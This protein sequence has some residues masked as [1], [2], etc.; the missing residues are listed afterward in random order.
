MLALGDGIFGWHNFLN[1][2][3]VNGDGL[4][5]PIDAL[6]VINELNAPMNSYP[7]TSILPLGASGEQLA[8]GLDVSCDGFVSPIDALLVINALNSKSFSH[9]WNFSSSGG[10]IQPTREASTGRCQPRLVESSSLLAELNYPFKVPSNDTLLSIKIRDQFFDQSKVGF[11][12]DALEVALVDEEGKSLVSPFT[13][14][15]E[16]LFN[17][18]E[19][20][21]F[22]AS[23]RVEFKQDTIVVDLTDIPVGT[24]GSVIVRLINN[25]LDTKSAVTIESIQIDAAGRSSNGQSAN[26]EDAIQH[27][28][29]DSK[30]TAVSI[31]SLLGTRI[32]EPLRTDSLPFDSSASLSTSPSRYPDR[33]IEVGEI[34]GG[35]LTTREE[36]DFY[37]FYADAGSI[38]HVDAQIGSLNSFR[39]KILSASSAPV[40]TNISFA[41]ANTIELPES[42]IYTFQI[43][44]FLPSS[45]HY[46]FQLWNVEPR[47]ANIDLD[48]LIVGSLDVPGAAQNY[49]FNGQVGQRIAF[50][51]LEGEGFIVGTVYEL[52]SPS[53]KKSFSGVQL[54]PE[55]V[56]DET[57]IYLLRVTRML[58][59]AFARSLGN[60]GN[61]AFRIRDSSTASSPLP[62]SNV[63]LAVTN[64]LWSSN[65]LDDTREIELSWTV[66]NLGSARSNLDSWSS[67]V[68]LVDTVE[69]ATELIPGY[70]EVVAD[71]RADRQ[72]DPGESYTATKSVTIPARI[73]GEF[74]IGVIADVHNSVFELD[75]E[76]N[77]AISNQLI[78][79]FPPKV[80]S[81]ETSITVST[82]RNVFE[83]GQ[84]ALLHGIAIPSRVDTNTIVVLDLS[85]S[86]GLRVDENGN[87]IGELEGIDTNG[88]GVL[89]ELDNAN[90]DTRTGDILD[91]EINSLLEIIAATP[92]NANRNIAVVAFGSRS[93]NFGYPL[94]P[95]V[96]LASDAF[97]QSFVAVSNESYDDMSKAIRSLS[98]INQTFARR[99]EVGLFHPFKIGSGNDLGLVMEEVE[100]LLSQA[101][102][103]ERTQIIFFADGEPTT[104]GDVTDETLER[105]AS[106]GV[107]FFGYQITGNSVSE[108]MQRMAR[109]IAQEPHSSGQTKLVSNPSNLLSAATQP[110]EIVSVTVNGKPVQALDPSG[111]F[112]AEVTIQEGDNDF[113]VESIDSNGT[114]A[115]IRIQLRGKPRDSNSIELSTLVDV[116]GSLTGVYGRT[117]FNA[118]KDQ[119]LVELATRN[120]GS[121]DSDIPVLVGIRNLSDP[122]IIVDNADGVFPDGMPYYD[123][124]AYVNNRRLAPGEVSGSPTISFRNAS[125]VQF[126]YELVFF[127]KLNAAP[128]ITSVP[129][130]FAEK[131]KPFVYKLTASD[132]DSD[133]LSYALIVSPN[134]MTIDPNDGLVTW[135]PTVDQ[136]GIHEVL[137]RVSDPRGGIAEQKFSLSVIVPP[138]NR[139]P[140]ITSFPVVTAEIGLLY[141][142][143]VSAR[144]SD[145]DVLSYAVLR[146]P[147]GMVIDANSG[148][149]R[150][151]PSENDLGNHDLEIKLD[152]GRGGK[153]IQRFVICVHVNAG[154]DPV[155]TPPVI[156]VADGLIASVDQ[157]FRTPVFVQ[158]VDA[159]PL[160]LSIKSAPPG[161][162]IDRIEV[163]DSLQQVA[164]VEHYITWTPS[165]DK[166]GIHA[167]VLEAVDGDGNRSIRE[168][169]LTVAPTAAN[170][171]PKI[172]S[173]YRES[174][175][176]GASFSYFAIAKDPDFDKLTWSLTDPPIGMTISD[177]GFVQWIP[178]LEQTGVHDI[179]LR[180]DDKRGGSDEQRLHLLVGLTLTNDPPRVVSSPKLI[181]SVEH[182]Y[183]YDLVAKDLDG[184][185]LQ[186]SLTSAPNGMSVH[187][188]NGTIR[189][190]P[191]EQ[192]YGIHKVVVTVSDIVGTTYDQSFSVEVICGN[193]P[194]IIE[195]S[196][197][198]QALSDRLYTYHVHASDVDDQLL[199]F[200]VLNGPDGLQI[201]TESGLIRWTPTIQQ[202]GPVGLTVQVSDNHGGVAIQTYELLVQ[203]SASPTNPN[204]PNSA[205]LGN[206]APVITSTPTF[207]AAVG[208]AYGYTVIAF[209][210]D[211][212][213]ISF[214][215]TSSPI[216]LTIDPN[217]GTLN[218]RPTTADEG[219][220]N[221]NVVATDERGAKSTQGYALAVRSNSLP[222]ITSLPNL[223]AVADG[224]YRYIVRATDID[225]DRLTY[226]LGHAI[227]GLRLDPSTGILTWLPAVSDLGIHLIDVV[228]SDGKGAMVAQQFNLEVVADKLAPQVKLS[229]SSTI[230]DIGG[231]VFLQVLATDNASVVERTLTVDGVA[232]PLD[233]LGRGHFTGTKQ[234]LVEVVATA[235]DAAGNV[236][237]DVL[238]IRILDPKDERGPTVSISS[239]AYDAEVSYLTDIVGTIRVPDGQQLDFYRI[240][241]APTDKVDL[242]NIGADSPHWKILSEGNTQV[243]NAKLATFDPTVLR[244]G[245]Y[246]VRVV[247]FNTNGQGWAEPLQLHAVGAAKIGQFN[248]EFIDLS[249]PLS[250]IPIQIV[251]KYDTLDADLEGDFGFGWSLQGAN[252]Q[253]LAAGLGTP[254][255]L[256]SSG[257]TFIPGKTK[258]Y[259]T[260]PNGERVGFSYSEKLISGGPLSAVYQPVFTADPGVYGALTAP[261]TI[262]RGMFG[263]LGYSPSE[264]TLATKQGLAYKYTKAGEL[265][266][267]TD[268]NGNVVTFSSGGIS[269]SNG[270][271]IDFKRDYRGRIGKVILPDGGE[272]KYAYDAVGDL[273]SFTNQVGQTHK[274]D[275][276][277][278]TSHFFAASFDSL[279][280]RSLKAVYS[281]D[282][283]FL[284]VE[285][286][287]GQVVNSQNFDV[288]AHLGVL[289]D[290]RGN[291]TTLEFDDRGNVLVETD[292][293]GFSK[294][295]FYE[296]PK[297]P[298]L[299]T[300][301]IEKDGHVTKREFDERGNLTKSIELGPLMMPFTNAMVTSYTYDSG[302]RVTSVT[303][304]RNN[305]TV[306]RYDG[307]GNL[308]QLT[309]ALGNSSYFTYS[310][311]G[312]VTD[313]T[314]FKG[315]DTRFDDYVGGQPRLITYGDGTRQR[316]EYN[317][318]G[319]TTYEAYLEPDG[320]IAWQRTQEY[321]QLGRL[322]EEV[323]G[324][325]T[326]GSATTRKL[327]YD[328][329]VLDWEIIVHPDSLNQNGTL[330]ESPSTPVAN[331]KSSITDYV[332]DAN[333]RLI[334][335]IDAEGGVINFRYDVDGNRIALR[336]PVG[337][338][339]TWLFDK[340]S[341]P[342]EERDPLY[343]ADVRA[344]E[345][346]FSSL[347]DDEFLELV[348][349]IDPTSASDP[350]FDDPSG[351]SCDTDTPAPHVILSCYDAVGNVEAKVDRNGRR[352]EYDFDFMR[353]LTEER[354]Y[355]LTDTLIRT[356]AYSFDRVGNM[357]AALDA[358]S[359]LTFTYDAINQQL[360]AD[361]AGTPQGPGVLL[362]YSYDANGNLE[363]VFDN[364]GIT[365]ASIYS[366]RNL[367]QVRQWFD[368]SEVDIPEI[369]PLR[370]E[371]SYNA[372]GRQSKTDRYASL[373][374]SKLIGHMMRE[375]DQAGRSTLI[376]FRNTAEE[377]L[378]H[379]AFK[380]DA[381]GRMAASSRAG[382]DAIYTSDLTGQ[383]TSATRSNSH[384]EFFTYD[385]NGNRTLPG[386]VTDIGNRLQT[387]GNYVYGYDAEGNRV[388][389]AEIDTGTITHYEYDHRNRLVRITEQKVNRDVIDIASYTY[390]VLD[391]RIKVE[392]IEGVT[393]TVHDREQAWVDFNEIAEVTTRYL[394]DNQIDML[395]AIAEK[396]QSNLFVNTDQLGSVVSYVNPNGELLR[397]ISYD[398]FGSLA[399]DSELKGRF[400][401]TGRDSDSATDLY[402]YRARYYDV[403]IGR[404]VSEDPIRFGGFDSQLT[405]YAQ[406]APPIFSDP[407]GLVAALEVGVFESNFSSYSAGLIGG[408]ASSFFS[409]TV[410]FAAEVLEELNI[411][412]GAQETFERKFLMRALKRAVYKS[413]ERIAEAAAGIQFNQPA[414]KGFSQG[415]KIGFYTAVEIIVVQ[416]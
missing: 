202:I 416:I 415:S 211:R 300:R 205:A 229:S 271:R 128:I 234:Q 39:Y 272:L 354:W 72:L 391:R 149:I 35:V 215:L 312:D 113:I 291:E 262:T 52:V 228:V 269:H 171:S 382:T 77:V 388:T 69:S 283:Q 403:S 214:S 386:Y 221:I 313:F 90:G 342:T 188:W 364:S 117:S 79:Y 323:L 247:A 73:I 120:D 197:K 261:G 282:N 375:Y 31:P 353:D 129:I 60:I 385:A 286:A 299:E 400:G 277:Q 193:V 78:T 53:G 102:K 50:D 155:D 275:Y 13:Q 103:A 307:N 318:Y 24:K 11:I 181:A 12:R 331:R 263:F 131:G 32:G 177:S 254:N 206:R 348:A 279:G 49:H 136:T 204:D 366:E 44:Q 107:D 172:N 127:A 258:V 26:S 21:P 98:Y 287:L 298:D 334:H 7:G 413:L 81:P 119:V 217:T 19:G 29:E 55:S 246:A 407:F 184:D 18:T 84:T 373:D 80:G 398:A 253:I 58:S 380:Y 378:S 57:G 14:N 66:T 265:Q 389:R 293:L 65:Q 314:D 178:T 112:F 303:D 329:E 170:L 137:L 135:A 330:I 218:W 339:T 359:S 185:I 87:V 213:E 248:L 297:N 175:V 99:S 20:L 42:G 363:S 372:A 74:Q 379:Y 142:Y 209:D 159:S 104:E 266:S 122:S 96:D 274:Y 138:P 257:G 337:N 360:T 192:Q 325:E 189:W 397:T 105:I 315:N 306:F 268:L 383:L 245:A 85:G 34:V 216:G 335:Q 121:F 223:Q 365:V 59:P 358:D 259:L 357:L 2:E 381:L 409:V 165:F 41:D 278:N 399:D 350:L 182:G 83:A 302:N 327:F 346:V 345:A 368:S 15:R 394:Y 156:V 369:A 285:D 10:Y 9:G 173:S 290:G 61:Y 321:D 132:P 157:I 317:I 4:V 139:P 27:L 251:R 111:Q 340:N 91:A 220:Y 239:P 210:A 411:R 174:L 267:I 284:H 109:L 86:T 273:R 390:D 43:E 183:R 190:N 304:A 243:E 405:R 198:T 115:S 396:S 241:I 168:L 187:P 162:S 36:I 54:P 68:F 153:T 195:S 230:I 252:A 408:F 244:N 301:I 370:F 123:F 393:F 179:L 186:F 308:A 194:P 108:P 144:D 201:N 219:Q 238:Q 167:V 296:D 355:D 232:V 404:F 100:R 401:F 196:P 101:P 88:D 328:G 227:P 377:I 249:I 376:D 414:A 166:I 106:Y 280:N 89:D 63:D 6:R 33:L 295:Y 347:S 160:L 349:P 48:E 341:Q 133:R 260:N 324:S 351:A 255:G 199:Y 233:K 97:R 176:P 38:I 309:N 208:E 237:Q 288:E 70:F 28:R 126:D 384:D 371:F 231:T 110:D 141:S 338:I 116:T 76:N 71:L 130:L 356:M 154:S 222:V 191:T 16:A 410:G 236:G 163:L 270:E 145:G 82:D 158:S 22:R 281:S 310:S 164:R 367:L 319:Q 225:D 333:L 75:E 374:R 402:F 361:S 203:D 322:I 51:V 146:G 47:L 93:G 64:L 40:L 362:T 395:L 45:G 326:D 256:F 169:A 289:R 5:T 134:G 344:R 152:D 406:N 56:L 150:W 8:L 207:F 3:D 180:V 235:S 305:T 124:T 294:R 17:I 148:N 240:E 125:Q 37:R 30:T 25:D 94:S 67:R 95:T 114:H 352:T 212:D 200:E 143:Q 387:D 23:G 343:W 1:I 140:V 332:Y 292:P 336:D 161:L 276:D 311:R 118:G 320:S 250:G 242:F 46:Q 224:T 62:T 316:L 147:Q 264:Y 412:T 92:E 151:M 226:S 392:T